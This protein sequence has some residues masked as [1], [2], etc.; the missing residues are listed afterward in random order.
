MQKVKDKD[1]PSLMFILL[2]LS[3]ESRI[4]KDKGCKTSN[5]LL[6]ARCTFYEK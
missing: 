3:P 1:L 5:E 2:E 4:V 6:D